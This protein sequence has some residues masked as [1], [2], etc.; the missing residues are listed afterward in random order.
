MGSN[1]LLNRPRFSNQQEERLMPLSDCHSTYPTEG[2]DIGLSAAFREAAYSTYR[3]I[4]LKR[5]GTEPSKQQQHSGCTNW[6][7]PLLISSTRS[8]TNSIDS[9]ASLPFK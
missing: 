2:T 9:V 7:F 4:A 1:N 3:L 6:G 5:K 8:G